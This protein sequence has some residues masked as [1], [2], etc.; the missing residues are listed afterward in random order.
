ML[1]NIQALRALAAYLVVFYHVRNIYKSL[2]G[3]QEWFFSL[4]SFGFSGVDVFFVISGY[5]IALSLYD[6]KKT[7]TGAL[8]YAQKRLSRI[9]LGYW[10]YFFMVLLMAVTVNYRNGIE[11]FDLWN[12]FLLLPI[13]P[14]AGEGIPVLG[15]YWTLTFELFFYL[16]CTA[17]FFINKKVFN[18]LLLAYAIFIL[19][20]WYYGPKVNRFTLLGFF[21]F[22]L[23]LEFLLG[24][25]VFLLR[26]YLF[27]RFL[28]PLWGSLFLGV[29]YFIFTT[30]PKAGG[31]MRVYAYGGMAVCLLCFFASLEVNDIYKAKGLLVKLGDASYSIYL[32]HL[33][34]MFLIS[35]L[36][37][38]GYMRRTLDF[39]IAELYVLV[40]CVFVG[41]FSLVF[42]KYIELPLYKLACKGIYLWT[43]P[44]VMLPAD[45]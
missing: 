20:Q 45:K 24:W 28:L 34:I 36:G 33:L 9:Y 43:K 16:I 14:R 23:I 13:D 27:N 8:I 42:Y 37:L 22:P 4:S 39:N 35:N 15:V 10:P 26:N 38:V 7:T 30:G 3:D 11:S 17:I 31:M 40:V 6:N 18:A 44:K 19:S 2:G 1:N 25:F 5:V 41:V 32:S 12:S 21:S 29:V